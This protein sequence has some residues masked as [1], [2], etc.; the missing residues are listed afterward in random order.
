MTWNTSAEGTVT[1]DGSEQT[2]STDTTNG[3]Y[4][5]VVDRNN[6]QNGDT[7]ELRLYSKV[8]SG[9]S[10]QLAYFGPFADVPPEPNVYSLP[11]PI[12]V[13]VKATLKQTAGTNRQYKWKLLRQ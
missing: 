10:Y 6:M 1:A 13:D 4:V 5:L 11:I 12:D 8:R 3:T 9:D 2:L 7:L